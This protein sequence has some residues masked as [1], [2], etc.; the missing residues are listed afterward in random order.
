MFCF[1]EEEQ[2]RLHAIT[3]WKEE[4]CA[5]SLAHRELS[6]LSGPSVQSA[7]CPPQQC[8]QLWRCARPLRQRRPD[9]TGRGALCGGAVPEVPAGRAPRRRAAIAAIRT[10]PRGPEVKEQL[11]SL[12]LQAE[13]ALGK[14]TARGCYRAGNQEV[15]GGKKNSLC[16][17]GS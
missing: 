15:M 4:H 17:E 12:C 8:R 1:S 10:P 6:V 9:G 13:R 5:F 16:G 11:A 14:G 3:L 7:V 2:K